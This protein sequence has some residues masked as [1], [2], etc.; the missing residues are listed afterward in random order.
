MLPNTTQRNANKNYNEVPP[1]TECSLLKSLQITNS[2]E[3]VDK[4]EFSYTVGE[5]LN[6][7]SHYENSGSKNRVLKLGSS[8]NKNRVAI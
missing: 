8:K 3:D 6:W 4:M 5:N 1:H 7:C 2:G